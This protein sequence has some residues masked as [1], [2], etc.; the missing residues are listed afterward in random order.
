M[1]VSAKIAALSLVAMLCGGCNTMENLHSAAVADRAANPEK[2]TE[3]PEARQ[4][5]LAPN[6]DGPIYQD[7]CAFGCPKAQPEQQ[8]VASG[9]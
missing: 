6:Q 5:Q 9:K 4:M 3:V 7:S 8:S 1:N 2:Y